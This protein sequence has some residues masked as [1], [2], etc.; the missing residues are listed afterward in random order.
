MNPARIFGSSS[1]SSRCVALRS[2]MNNTRGNLAYYVVYVLVFIFCI[3]TYY[4]NTP[5]VLLDNTTSDP[6]SSVRPSPSDS[7]LYDCAHTAS[8]GPRRRGGEMPRLYLW[9]YV[10]PPHNNTRNAFPCCSPQGKPILT[11]MVLGA[12]RGTGPCVVFHRSPPLLNS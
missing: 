11:C 7:Y 6:R 5:L 9:L 3:N 8:W 2:G 1:N 4:Q 12:S 10:I